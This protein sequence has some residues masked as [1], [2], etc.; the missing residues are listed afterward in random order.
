MGTRYQFSGVINAAHFF[1]SAHLFRLVPVSNRLCLVFLFF[2]PFFV[3][4]HAS[5]CFVQVCSLA[6]SLSYELPL[7]L[8]GTS[9][10]TVFAFKLREHPPNMEG[11]GEPGGTGNDAKTDVWNNVSRPADRQTEL[12][13]VVMKFQHTRKSIDRLSCSREQV[14]LS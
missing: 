2:L 4:F 6:S 1:R 11:G 12:G 8:A 9:E 14:R 5:S 3:C 13:M 7:V 10:G